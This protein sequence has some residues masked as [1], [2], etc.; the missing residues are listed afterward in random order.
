VKLLIAILLTCAAALAAEPPPATLARTADRIVVAADGSG[1]FRTVQAAVDFA[2]AHREKPVVIFIRKGRYE[3]LVRIGR[4]KRHVHLVGEDRKGT[5]IAFTNNDKLNPGWIRRAVLGCEADDFVL[6]NLTVQNTTP[7]KGSQAEAVFVNGERCVLRNADFLSFQDTLNLSGRVY[8]AD[9]YIEGDVDYVWGYGT[10]CFERCELRTMHDGYI[11]QARNPAAR[12][13]YVF[14]DCR[15][16]AVPD[17]KKCW[18]ARIETGRFPASHVAFI[19]CA[20]G[21]HILPAGWE[22]TGPASEALRF[23]EFASTDLEGKPLDVSQRNS[24]AKQLT[25]E[26]AATASAAK[27]LAGIDGWNPR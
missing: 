8:V 24:V 22:V 15:L 17:V 16:T 5:V 9:S 7:Y 10:A 3:E 12:A 25:M 20:M 19:R 2:E 13:G 27:I 14:L 23:E 21:P 18:L 11:V 6:E 4:E 26:Q 1:D